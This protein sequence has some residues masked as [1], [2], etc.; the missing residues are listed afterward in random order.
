MT[1]FL[2]QTEYL[3]D[4]LP[5]LWFGLVVVSLGGY[6]LLDGF[7][8][9]LG[10]LYADATEK[11]KRTMLAA[12]GPVWKANEVWLVLFGTVL[13]AAFPAVYANLLSRHYL[14]VFAIL[15]ALS[16]RG[17]GSK[18]R[19]ERDDE[20]W[21]R[22]WDACFVAGSTLSP[23]L[24]GAFV[25]S[26]VLGTTTAFAP[27]PVAVGLTVVAL[28][29]VLGAAFLGL[30][31]EGS[32]RE[33]V[34]RRGRMATGVYVVVLLATVAVL[35]GFHPELRPKIAAMSTLLVVAVTAASA[36]TFVFASA[37]ARYRL[38]VAGAG[39]VAAAFVAY[40]AYLLYPSVDP[41]AGLS[42]ADAV[43]SPLPLNLA[44]IFAVTFLPVI[45]IYFTVLYSVF[46][47]PANP[48][49]SYG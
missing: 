29:V 7:D 35:Y 28:C 43:V 21:T 44:S 49:E 1:E 32:L 40:V 17:L 22:F 39:G 24:L 6:L 18:L 27:G 46:S 3:V 26:W 23:F 5:E 4:S 47:G 42:I 25:A 34:S 11:E 48:E 2:S 10:I 12:F 38:A 16:L 30:K 14:L 8:F 45:A 37:R 31:T 9:G 36:A 15:L 20:A 33:T 41:A 13:F 19:E